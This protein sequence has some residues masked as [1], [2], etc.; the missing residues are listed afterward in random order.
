MA[1]ILDFLTARELRRSGAVAARA[2]RLVATWTL[3][4]QG[5]LV[6]TWRDM[7]LPHGPAEPASA[8]EAGVCA[9]RRLAA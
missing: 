4:E 9:G 3:T 6:C 7:Q 5:K 8:D 1:A 2:P